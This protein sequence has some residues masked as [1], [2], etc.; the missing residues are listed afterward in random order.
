VTCFE[1]STDRPHAVA[2]ETRRRFLVTDHGQAIPGNATDPAK[3][4]PVNDRGPKIEAGPGRAGLD[5]SSVKP[6]LARDHI[7]WSSRPALADQMRSV[8]SRLPDR[9]RSPSGRNC[10]LRTMS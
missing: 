10:R 6:Q 7:F 4:V 1:R 8:P 9:M 2:D 3:S 5:L